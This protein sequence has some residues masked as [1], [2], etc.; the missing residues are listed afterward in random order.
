MISEVARFFHPTTDLFTLERLAD[1]KDTV[2][3]CCAKTSALRECK[4]GVGAAFMSA[5][6]A[7]HV[8]LQAPDYCLMYSPAKVANL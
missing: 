4:Q 1:K 6:V 5:R 8:R 7:G 2:D 3:L